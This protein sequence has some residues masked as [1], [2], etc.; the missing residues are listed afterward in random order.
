[1][2]KLR[3]EEITITA[4]VLSLMIWVMECKVVGGKTLDP[5]YWNSSN[6]M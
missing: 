3:M 2:F 6:P 1:M 5:I 4:I